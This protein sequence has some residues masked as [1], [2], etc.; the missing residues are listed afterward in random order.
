MNLYALGLVTAMCVNSD[1]RNTTCEPV[2][3]AFTKQEGYYQQGEKAME[4]ATQEVGKTNAMLLGTSY[5]YFRDKHL[6]LTL[7][8]Q[9]KYNINYSPTR[10]SAGITFRIF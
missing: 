3:T 9:T 6:R 2:A 8:K 10:Y 1:V 5:I 4:M 7:G